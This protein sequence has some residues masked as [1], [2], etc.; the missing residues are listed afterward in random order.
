MSKVAIKKCAQISRF[1]CT[2]F[3][4]SA[5]ISTFNQKCQISSDLLRLITTFYVNPIKSYKQMKSSSTKPHKFQHFL[6]YSFSY[7]IKNRS[8]IFP[9]FSFHQNW[10]NLNWSLWLYSLFVAKYFFDLF[11]VNIAHFPTCS[12]R[13]SSLILPFYLHLFQ[14]CWTESCLLFFSWL[15]VISYLILVHPWYRAVSWYWSQ[16][17]EKDYCDFL[18]S[19]LFSHA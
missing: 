4:I 7:W 18:S 3:K 5:Q 14:F 16:N 19:M 12:L 10:I 6:P 15:T 1:L 17:F 2:N 9:I 13:H 11:S 8:N